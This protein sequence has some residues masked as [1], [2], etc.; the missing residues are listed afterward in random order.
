MFHHH[1]HDRKHHR[2]DCNLQASGDGPERHSGRRRRMFD[3]GD[4]RFVIIALIAEKPSY[5]YEIIKAIEDRVAGAYSPSP[6]LVYP[7]LTLLDELGLV[8]VADG[9][10]TK[11]LYSITEEGGASLAQNRPAVDAIFARMA[12]IS[13]A[14]G[15]GPAPSI[16]RAAV[17]LRTALKLRVNR[18]GLTEVQVAAITATLDQAAQAIEAS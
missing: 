17:N 12:A 2:P 16:L 5:G 11:K 15:E 10:G 13:A 1:H 7:T 18:G 8:T 14:T 9:P 4:L 3:Q 6:G